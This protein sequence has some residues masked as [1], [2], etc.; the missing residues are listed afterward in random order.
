[1]PILTPEERLRMIKTNAPT[2]YELECMEMFTI[3]EFE[4]GF[5]RTND[6]LDE[7]ME[8]FQRTAR[9]AFGVAG[10]SMVAILTSQ[11]DLAN[12]ACGTYLHEVIQ[13]IPIKYVIEYYSENPGVKDGDIWFV[14]DALYGGIHNPDAL[15]FMPV[16]HSG[17]LI[18]WTS[19]GAHTSETGGV[20]PGGMEINAQSRFSEGFNSPPIKVGENFKLRNDFLGLLESYG[21]RAPQMVL[22]DLRARCGAADRARARLAEMAN[23]K[24]SAYIVGLLQKMLLVAEEGARKRIS[25]WPD[26]TYRCVNFCDAVGMQE[27]LVR[28]SYMT[29]IKKEDEITFDFTGTSP[30]NDSSYNAHVQAVVGHISNFIYEY[31]FHDLPISNATFVPIQ[32]KFPQNSCLNPDVRAAT[33]CSP[34]IA[35]GVMSGLH[36]VFAKLMFSTE[37]WEQVTASHGNAGNAYVL[38][39]LNQWN[40]PYADTQAYSLNTEGQGG[41]VNQDGTDAFGFPW[42]AFGRAPDV[43]LMENELP[44]L[45][46]VSQHWPDSGGPG[47]HRGGC[48]T[49]QLWVAY[50]NKN[51]WFLCI[52][53]NSNLQTPQGLFG[54]YAPPTVPGISI[55]KAD[56]LEK[57][58]ECAD[59]LNL[60][61]SSLI[62]KDLINGDW[63]VEFLARAVRMYRHGDVISFCFSAGGSGY[64]DPLE[65]DPKAI[66][67]DLLERRISLWSAINVYKVACNPETYEVDYKKT[68]KLREEA[69]TE[70]LT[71]GKP[72][73]HFIKTWGKKA[74]PP[75]IL[76]FYG[77]WPD[78][79]PVAP[80]I[81]P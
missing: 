7:A 48:G 27:A 71:K 49:F 64:G 56:I 80:L 70:R 22:A 74:P 52:A 63:K 23:R 42:C 16:F 37:D 51:V 34:M 30:E 61:F 40:I 66:A 1:M 29:V 50:H 26:G 17:Q 39:G 75:E 10:D 45:I 15:V 41:R 69:R 33:S 46:P 19:A 9:S 35:T 53:D 11:G 47:K 60:D 59:G 4:I 8:I 78:A 38:A 36:N 65:R 2:T 54:G 57:L 25:T 18:A 24:G 5:Q 81:R 6:I 58:E 76:K 43:E 20:E 12:G 62:K 31:V 72:Y 77:S 79:K 21:L 68:Q 55:K 13:P 32:F 73:S 28:S 44:I 67:K 3:G 14:N